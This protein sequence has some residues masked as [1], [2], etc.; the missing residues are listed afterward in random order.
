MDFDLPKFLK[1]KNMVQELLIDCDKHPCDLTKKKGK[2]VIPEAGVP[3]PFVHGQG[4][5]VPTLHEEPPRVEG[6]QP[7]ANFIRPFDEGFM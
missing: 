6:S 1:L 3:D 2:P 4:W 5:S 7:G